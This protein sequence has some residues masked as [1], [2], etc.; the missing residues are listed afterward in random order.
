M[1]YE[2]SRKMHG[3]GNDKPESKSIARS[4]YI[5]VKVSFVQ[6]KNILTAGII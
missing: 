5:S 1:D 3:M 4:P 2:K 6:R